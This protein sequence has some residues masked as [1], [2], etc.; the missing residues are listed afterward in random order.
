MEDD[1]SYEDYIEI[2]DEVLDNVGT[3]VDI[4]G[5]EIQQ[6]VSDIDE[7]YGDNISNIINLKYQDIAKIVLSS[8]LNLQVI[9]YYNID[10]ISLSN[11]ILLL[12]AN[13]VNTYVGFNYSTNDGRHGYITVAAHTK[14]VLIKDIVENETL[15]EIVT[16]MYYLSSR[17]FYYYQNN[18]Y[19]TLDGTMIETN[20]L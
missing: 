13:K 10:S 9:D 15:P 1:I 14:A 19:H 3:E 11:Q 5:T 17:E 6:N 18:G 8:Y 20:E 12:D 4:L 2:E 16:Q 7:I